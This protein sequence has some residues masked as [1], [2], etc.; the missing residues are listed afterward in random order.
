MKKTLLLAAALMVVTATMASAQRGALSLGWS[1]CR[2]HGGGAPVATFACTTNGGPGALLVGGFIPSATANLNSLNSAFLYVDIYQLGSLDA[3]WQFTDPPV[4]GCRPLSIWGLNFDNGSGAA[5]CDRSYWGDVGNPVAADRFF[6]P[7][8][9]ANHGTLRL[10]TAV[11]AQVAQSTPQI[12]VGAE[13]YVFGARLGRALSTGAGACA[14]CLNRTCLYFALA[15]FF[16]TNLDNFNV[17]EVGGANIPQPGNA[18]VGWQL[19]VAETGCAG[20]PVRNATWGS[21]KSL[22]R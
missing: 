11:D 13:S 7:S 20:T 10:L 15:E 12:P 2:V 16:Q 21:I 1:S 18:Y 8:Y 19:N 5:I 17:G 9:A 4:T 14:G 6:Y 22:Y 3:W